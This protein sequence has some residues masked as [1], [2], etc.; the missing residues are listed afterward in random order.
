MSLPERKD[1]FEGKSYYWAQITSRSTRRDQGCALVRRNPGSVKRV[2]FL[3]LVCLTYEL[4][5]SYIERTNS[6]QV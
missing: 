6:I 5:Q 3:I 4:F 1:A 2:E